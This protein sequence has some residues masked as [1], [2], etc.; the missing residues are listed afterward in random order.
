MD[1]KAAI[2]TAYVAWRAGKTTLFAIPNWFLVP[3]DCSKILALYMCPPL[4]HV[5]IFTCQDHRL[6]ST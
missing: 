5:H 2:S 3:I 6:K 1:S 4:L